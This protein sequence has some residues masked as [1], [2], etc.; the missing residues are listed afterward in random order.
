ME[1][2]FASMAELHLR[3][4]RGT[5]TLFYARFGPALHSIDHNSASGTFGNLLWFA[6]VPYAALIWRAISGC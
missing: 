4:E 2:H 5:W 3:E 1:V 6:S